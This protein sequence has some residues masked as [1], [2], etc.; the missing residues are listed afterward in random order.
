MNPTRLI[1]QTNVI[2]DQFVHI[3]LETGDLP[4]QCVERLKNMQYTCTA[5]IIV[6]Q[7]PTCVNSIYL[8]NVVRSRG[9]QQFIE[10]TIRGEGVLHGCLCCGIPS[11]RSVL[12]D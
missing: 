12:K 2:L 6:A 9:F 11:Y 1:K 4:T 7:E 5:Y 10:C 3:R 8:R